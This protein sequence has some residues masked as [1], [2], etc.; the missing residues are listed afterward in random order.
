MTS[1]LENYEGKLD[2]VIGC[3]FSGKTTELMRRI[4]MTQ[5]ITND[6][7]IINHSLDDRYTTNAVCSH[8]DEEIATTFTCSRLVPLLRTKEY[9][10]CQF[11]FIDEAQFFDDLI[12]FATVSV[13]QHKKKV[14]ICGLDGDYDRKPFGSIL[15]L[16]PLCDSIT[17]KKSFCVR[18]KNGK[19]AIFSKN[20]QT[21][22]E[23]NTNIIIG[24]GDIYK[25]LCRMHYLEK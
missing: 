6:I 23:T 10:Q 17:K 22:I 20:I 8:D 12:Q 15:H 1:I 24:S 21:N 19:E 14:T 11:I 18:C 16:I 9:E 25:P 13:D 7:L 3:M 5:V 4:R 2:L